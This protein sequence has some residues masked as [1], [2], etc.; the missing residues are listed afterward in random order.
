M[1]FDSNHTNSIAFHLTHIRSATVRNMKFTQLED[2][3]S[4]TNSKSHI[5]IS[6]AVYRIIWEMCCD[7][8]QSQLTEVRFYVHLLVADGNWWW[9]RRG[10]ESISH[11]NFSSQIR[12][13]CSRNLPRLTIYCSVLRRSFSYSLSM[14]CEIHN[15]V[16]NRC[17]KYDFRTLVSLRNCSNGWSVEQEKLDKIFITCSSLHERL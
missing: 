1:I 10:L 8:F 2:S 9:K 17:S 7:D 14:C 6:L 15:G 11:F 5:S 3:N 13:H 4:V 12:T 16:D